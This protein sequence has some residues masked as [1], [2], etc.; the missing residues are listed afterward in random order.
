VQL[1]FF[2]SEKVIHVRLKQVEVPKSLHN[3]LSEARVVPTISD[4]LDFFAETST[5]ESPIIPVASFPILYS[6]QIPGTE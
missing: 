2:D 5:C 3:M 6:G 4:S 1:F